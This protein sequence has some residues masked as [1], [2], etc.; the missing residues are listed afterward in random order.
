MAGVGVDGGAIGQNRWCGGLGLE[1]RAWIGEEQ[2]AEF[3]VSFGC[4]EL[5]VLDIA[6]ALLLRELGLDDVSVGGLAGLLALL[7]EGEE[8]VGIIGRLLDHCELG[9]CRGNTVVERNHGGEQAAA[10]DL[11]SSGGLCLLRAGEQSRR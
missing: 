4:G 11:G 6:D 1:G 3:E 2:H 8:T 7:G 10:S 9:I 5:R